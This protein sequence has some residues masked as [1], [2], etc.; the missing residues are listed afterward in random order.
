MSPFYYSGSSKFNKSFVCLIAAK[1]IIKGS[2]I[3]HKFGR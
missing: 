3:K 1:A 2:Y